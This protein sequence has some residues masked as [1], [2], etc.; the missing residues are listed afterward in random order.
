MPRRKSRGRQFGDEFRRQFNGRRNRRLRRRRHELADEALFAFARQMR[1][2]PFVRMV[3]AGVVF[4]IVV[5]VMMAVIV[6]MIGVCNLNRSVMLVGDQ[7]VQSRRTDD[8]TKA[9]DGEQRCG[10]RSSSHERHG[11]FEVLVRNSAYQRHKIYAG[12]QPGV[13]FHCYLLLSSRR[14]KFQGGTRVYLH[15]FCNKE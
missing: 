8:G 10:E 13:G 12:S 2:P 1:M 15:I 14:V 4:M 3:M 9:V 5:I 6:S 11:Q 7:I